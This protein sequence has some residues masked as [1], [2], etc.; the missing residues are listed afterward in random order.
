MN[1]EDVKKIITIDNKLPIP[2]YKQIIESVK[3]GLEEKKIFKGDILPSINEISN[4]YGLAKGTVVTAYQELREKS[5]ISSQPGKGFFVANEKTNIELNIFVL[6]DQITPYKQILFQSFKNVLGDKAQ[7]DI[8][9]YYHNEQIFSRYID[10]N[11]GRYNYYV[12]M[13]H[14]HTDVSLVVSKIPRDK[15]LIL[16]QEITLLKDTYTHLVQNFELDMYSGLLKA[17]N[18]L[19][20]Y[21]EIILVS[22]SNTFQF[23]PKGITDGLYKFTTENSFKCLIV[24]NMQS[25]VLQKGQV[26]IIFNDNEMVELITKCK[27]ESLIIGK[28]IGIISYDETPVKQILEGGIT[29]ISTDFEQMGIQAANIILKKQKGYFENPSEFIL[30]KSL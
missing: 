1:T 2:I 22:G 8:F 4:A 26:F 21:S 30:R 5:I 15:T 11:I 17:K 18:E 28:D 7:T 20:K 12:I 16:N 19:S 6:F 3:K 29:V 10:E 14:L 25:I 24:G 13:P 27:K 9:F 23:I